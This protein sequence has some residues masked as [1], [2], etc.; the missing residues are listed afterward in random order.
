MKS[1][2]HDSDHGAVPPAH[3]H[4]LADDRPIAGETRLPKVM[5]EDHD[6]LRARSFLGADERAAPFRRD[7]KDWEE[8]RGNFL[9]LD[10]LRLSATSQVDPRLPAARALLKRVPVS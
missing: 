7:P 1:R 5:P 2:R 6:W 4:G 3:G 10:F 8:I 9:N